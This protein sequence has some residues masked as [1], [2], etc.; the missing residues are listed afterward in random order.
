M[1]WNN[2][3]SLCVKHNTKPNPVAK[4]LNLSS[5]SVT[6]WKNGA[7]P[8]DTTLKKIA[9]YFGVPVSALT[10]HSAAPTNHSNAII[11]D[12]TKMRMIPVFESVSAGLGTMPQESAVDY[13]SMYIPS[14]SEAADTFCVKVTGDSMSPEIENGDVIQVH[15][16][17]S[18]D[19]GS[20]A[21]ALV[22]GDE[23]LVKKVTYGAGYV[24]LH[25]LNPIYP[26][27]RF[28]GADL[29]NVAILGLVKN[30]IKSPT[31][32]RIPSNLDTAMQQLTDGLS[33]SELQEVEQFV[34]Y[35]KSKRT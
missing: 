22:N 32:H 21:V 2:F 26:P 16:Q 12:P 4:A 19:S 28:E 3:V 20:I 9:D 30:I 27:L 18:V 25:S 1:F 11:L 17:C 24:E 14:D 23:A 10:E 31:P 35:L 15:K 5:G 6:K 29:A 13:M 7:T 8:N 33:P 34:K